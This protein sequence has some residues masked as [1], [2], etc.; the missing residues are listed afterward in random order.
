MHIFERL[1]LSTRIKAAALQSF[2]STHG[3]STSPIFERL[4]SI[5]TCTAEVKTAALQRLPARATGF[6]LGHSTRITGTSLT[7]EETEVPTNI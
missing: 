7:V 5:Y 6:W 1:F 4:S 2:T 3:F